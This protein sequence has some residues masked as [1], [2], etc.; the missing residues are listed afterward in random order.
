MDF[1]VLHKALL[2]YF[3]FYC[4]TIMCDILY[5]LNGQIYPSHDLFSLFFIIEIT[6]NYAFIQTGT[7]FII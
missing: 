4:F 7:V 6:R 3:Y 2:T 1:I 5:M